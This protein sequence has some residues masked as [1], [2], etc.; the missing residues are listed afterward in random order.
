MS[1]VQRPVQRDGKKMTVIA[2][3]SPNAMQSNS[4][5]HF[6][7][8]EIS[9]TF[10]TQLLGQHYDSRQTITGRFIQGIGTLQKQILQESPESSTSELILR[11]IHF[12]Y[13]WY[14]SKPQ[15]I[16]HHTLSLSQVFDVIDE[17]LNLFV[18]GNPGA[19]SKFQEACNGAETLFRH[20]PFQ[21][22]VQFSACFSQLKWS[23]Y[24]DFREALMR[25]L[26]RMAIGVLGQNHYLPKILK[27]IPREH[28]SAGLSSRVIRITTDTTF[29]QF[30][31]S[32][33]DLLNCMPHLRLLVGRMH[34][35]TGEESTLLRNL[36][37]DVL[38]TNLLGHDTP[39]DVSLLYK[40]G[41]LRLSQN[42]L[43]EAEELLTESL[44]LAGQSPDASGARI[45][46]VYMLT[47]SCLGVLF[48]RRGDLITQTRYYRLALEWSTSV[49]PN[50][51]L[52]G[53]DKRRRMKWL[54][55]IVRYHTLNGE[56]L[57]VQSLREQYYDL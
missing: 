16:Y 46:K 10:H 21:I 56:E 38:I 33:T 43:D 36:S 32:S 31:G 48:G 23:N 39:K 7:G 49:V 3:R 52:N 35:D 5:C 54:D 26:A 34:R 11:H 19:F 42:R 41:Y 50:E 6:Q 40:L 8:P 12:Y 28:T 22:I 37:Q 14:P 15:A 51:A 44:A 1:R 29:S 57:E 20:Q 9:S 55:D 4:L 30:Q 2:Q 45:S 24:P 13:Q 53:E 25:Y 27:L 17:G 47:L 18:A